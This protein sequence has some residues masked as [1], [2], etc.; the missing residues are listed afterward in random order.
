MQ[1]LTPS[2][3][4]NVQRMLGTT[5][6]EDAAIWMDEMRSNPAYDYMK[7]WHYVNTEKG[8]IYNPAPNTII[9]ELQ[10]VYHELEQP[11][12]LSAE[13][14]KTDLKLLFH[15]LGDLHQPLHV[16]YASDRGGNSVQVMFSGVATDLHSVWDTK[17]IESQHITAADCMK[18]SKF[19]TDSARTGF[20]PSA[21]VE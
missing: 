15:L 9:S 11:K 21:F 1:Y 17:I 10:R 5:T 4:K 7:P 20:A 8:K 18:L 2:A 16:G 14:Q 19:T 12:K 13:G 3:Q 6:P